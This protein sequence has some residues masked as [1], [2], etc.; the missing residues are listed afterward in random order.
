M[1]MTTLAI[2]FL[3]AGCNLAGRPEVVRQAGGDDV[4]AL[5]GGGT[6][7]IQRAL[8][9]EEPTCFARARNFRG[10]VPIPCNLAETVRP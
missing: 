10:F 1:R 7:L 5:P 6:L 2:A 9:P 8:Q 3:A 4:V